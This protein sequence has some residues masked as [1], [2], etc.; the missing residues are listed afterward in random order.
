MSRRWRTEAAGGGG[1]TGANTCGAGASRA[2]AS[3]CTRSSIGGSALAAKAIGATASLVERVEADSGL[4]TGFERTGSIRVAADATESEMFQGWV[5]APPEEIPLRRLTP[6]QLR[7]EEPALAGGEFVALYCAT[8]SQVTP[9]AYVATIVRAAT[10]RGMDLQE[11][12]AAEAFVTDG[13]RVS[14]V[15][16]A[17]GDL[18]ADAVVLAAGAWSG[19]FR[20]SGGS[21]LPV[22]PLRGARIALDPGQSV[23][24]HILYTDAC[25]LA[26]KPNGEIWVGATEE[27]RGFHDAVTARDVRE[28][29][30]AAVGTLPVLAEAR[31]VEGR[32]GLRPT[33]PDLVPIIGRVAEGL[34]V[35]TGHWRK[36]VMLAA[37]TAR[38]VRQAVTGETP[39]TDLAPFA[40]SRFG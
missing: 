7:A 13:S 9:A 14:G 28:L 6:A 32:A 2:N 3:T 38:L 4:S 15:R 12:T 29:G 22:R 35:A 8:E 36:G 23:L 34:F 40:A 33:T 5:T 24:R 19:A 25:D 18:G 31:F 39:E 11:G 20:A 10:N 16:T 27:D 37:I 17:A 1:A 26:P 30:S 21:S